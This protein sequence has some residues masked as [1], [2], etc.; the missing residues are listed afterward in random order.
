MIISASNIPI[1]IEYQL[2]TGK[3]LN[4][5]IVPNYAGGIASV[6]TQNKKVFKPLLRASGIAD[7]E[8]RELFKVDYSIKDYHALANFRVEAFTAASVQAYQLQ[9][10]LKR[11]AEDVL[12]KNNQ[13]PEEFQ[14]QARLKII[15]YVPV[16]DVPP[17]GHLKTNFNTGIRSS[18][19]AAEYIRLQS[20]EMKKI[21]P[22]Y[23]YMTRNDSHVREE[24]EELHGLIFLCEDPVLKKIY[25]PNGWN[26]R[27]FIIVV[28]ARELDGLKQ[29]GDEKLMMNLT[30]KHRKKI[31]ADANISSDF[32]RN[33]GEVKS[34][35]G[36]WN[37]SKMKE[38]NYAEIEKAM[39]E[40]AESF[41]IPESDY[42]V[43]NVAALQLANDNLGKWEK[44]D[45][46]D[47]EKDRMVIDLD[48]ELQKP[49]ADILKNPSEIWGRTSK[50][51]DEVQSDI[52]YLK[53]TT[54]GV[55]VITVRNGE[56]IETDVVDFAY[57]DKNYR[58]GTIMH[59]AGITKN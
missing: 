8:N 42:P 48:P 52:Y 18:F 4:A 12:L 43:I 40:Y 54:E 31:I 3:F 21:Y 20:D 13:N 59:V 57:A 38:I 32:L 19:H 15:E 17:S 35:W 37:D 23:K 5:G 41:K 49:V 46:K 27:C 16:Q 47:V 39:K 53:Y 33:P 2:L 28:N 14:K 22:A 44:R 11:I 7:E 55:A 1:N 29:S 9:Q 45:I 34:I 25:P 36:K 6:I 30:D 24:H 58:R 26:C 10:E 56:V 50:Q 51:G